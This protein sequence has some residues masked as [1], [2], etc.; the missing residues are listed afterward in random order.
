MYSRQEASKL[1]HEF[2]TV[3]GQ[4]MSPVLNAEGE[5]INWINYKT[6]EK[7]IAFKLHADSKRSVV[8]IEISHK[9]P[10]IQQII[11]DQFVQFKSLLVNATKEEWTWQL[12]THDENGKMIS[13]IF[14]EKNGISIFKREDWPEL[15]SFFKPLILA[16]DAFW[17]DVKYAFEQ[18]R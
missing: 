11:F 13:R 10:E 6:G 8:A 4:Y 7:G 18:W 16:L 9:D 14:I 2:W 17:S 1:R 15:I 3:F 12:H 5:K